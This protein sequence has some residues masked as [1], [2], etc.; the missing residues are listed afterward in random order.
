MK[1]PEI[2][3]ALSGG[4][5]R[6][7]AFHLG[8][9]TFLAEKGAM[10]R[11]KAISTVSGGTLLTGLILVKNNFTWPDSTAYTHSVRPKIFKVLEEGLIE[12]SEQ[13]I[14]EYT[15]S[16]FKEN[17]LLELK[18]IFTK[19]QKTDSFRSFSEK[20]QKDWGIN[21]ILND[22]DLKNGPNWIINGTS[23]ETGK[24]AYF[25]AKAK[26]LKC[27]EAPVLEKL[28]AAEERLA[29]IV[30][31]SAAVP[32]FIG[33][34]KPVLPI[35]MSKINSSTPSFIGPY[36]PDDEKC[37]AHI[38]DGGIYDNLGTEEFLQTGNGELKKSKNKE[39][40]NYKNCILLISDA[41]APLNK[42]FPNNWFDYKRILKVYQI[43]A[44]QVRSLRIR[45][46]NQNFLKKQKGMGA[47]FRIGKAITSSNNKLDFSIEN[48]QLKKEK[49]WQ[50]KKEV[51]EAA[52][53]DT[54]IRA[55]TKRELEILHKHGYESA[56]YF[57]KKLNVK[58]L[59]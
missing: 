37:I 53:I 58:G 17:L 6:S 54:S 59:T 26:K 30:A 40:K 51:D 10:S 31:M 16:R 57:T 45:D 25:D 15:K 44:E 5:V 39:Y 35:L 11:I 48:L 42:S 24:R 28:N 47:H 1:K 46:F 34:Y 23:A 56:S 2:V 38:Y 12:I 29:D 41:G 21:G 32:G 13:K 9:L 22:L 18:T 3:L 8:I 43:T 27:Y 4:G 19:T 49:K 36:N 55:L 33:P 52:G 14:F 7:M 20:L 50:S